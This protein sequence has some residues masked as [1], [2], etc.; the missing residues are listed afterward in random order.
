VDLVQREGMGDL[1]IVRRKEGYARVSIY[2][3]QC[4]EF[5]FC[6]KY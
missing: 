1:F 5:I 6:M 4:L 3:K 2:W